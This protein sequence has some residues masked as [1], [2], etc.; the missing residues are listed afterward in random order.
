MFSNTIKFFFLL[1]IAL[2]AAKVVRAQNNC[3]LLPVKQN[4]KWGYIN[5][6]GKL[7]IKPRFAVAGE[8]SEG[9]ADVRDEEGWFYYIDER[10]KVLPTSSRFRVAEPF[11]EGL[12]L[13][14]GESYDDKIGFIDRSGQMVIAPQF[15]SFTGAI[16]GR[17]EDGLCHVQI[18][19]KVGFIDRT[20]RFVIEPR[21]DSDATYHTSNFYEGLAM[22]KFG[23]K[24]GFIDRSGEFVIATRFH[25]ASRFSEGLASVR[26]NNK[27]GY[28]DTTGQFVIEPRY[29]LASS[30]SEGLAVVTTGASWS[31]GGHL[32]GGKNSVIDKNG[33]TV[34]DDP[35]FG[36]I[37]NFSEGL[38]PAM[39]GERWGFI[40]TR[41]EVVIKP[42]YKWAESFERGL[43]RVTTKGE[44]IGYIDRRG[45]YIWRPTK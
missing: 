6:Q 20:G 37:G 4:D 24:Q 42:Q 43:A 22:V 8:F 44:A 3:Q 10:G 29:D 34:I 13:V 12:A 5:C 23:R 14:Q 38:A 11:S 26:V 19:G 45:S 7:V 28:I 35:R 1:C 2:F 36:V 18:N 25:M 33:A 21:F 32:V 41:G 17:F 27:W 30:F 9:F 40:D 15:D 16:L 31:R 39:I